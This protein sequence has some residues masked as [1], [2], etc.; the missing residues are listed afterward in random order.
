MASTTT[1]AATSTSA[2]AYTQPKGAAMATRHLL[3]TVQ[4]ATTPV[5]TL[6]TETKPTGT[7]APAPSTGYS[8]TTRDIET[9]KPGSV[10]KLSDNYKQAAVAAAK[11]T[12]VPSQPPKG[13]GAVSGTDR[14]G[15]QR[16]Q[17]WNMSD[18]KRVQHEQLLEA[19]QPHAQRYASTAQ[20]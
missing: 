13:L 3:T 10:A 5:R 9:C 1:T 17:S 12:T 8:T 16:Q 7:P 14:P 19:S 6:A 18:A 20:K 2:N 4:P 15:V 11:S